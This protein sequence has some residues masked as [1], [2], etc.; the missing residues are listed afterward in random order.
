MKNTIDEIK[1]FLLLKHHCEVITVDASST[2]Q[3]YYLVIRPSKS[4]WLNLP[5]IFH[6]MKIHMFDRKV[7]VA[8]KLE[9]F[10]QYQNQLTMF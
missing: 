10:L 6:V 8:V 5:S 2:S 7:Q 3:V 9:E 4:E 1:I